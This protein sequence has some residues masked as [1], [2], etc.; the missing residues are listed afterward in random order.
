MNSVEDFITLREGL[1]D[2]VETAIISCDLDTNELFKIAV[3]ALTEACGI[4]WLCET[5]EGDLDKKEAEWFK[6]YYDR[7][8]N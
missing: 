4:E 1:L 3:D 2:I 8:T 5:L 7:R 6:Q